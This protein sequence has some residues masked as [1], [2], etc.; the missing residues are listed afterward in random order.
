MKIKFYTL[1][2]LLLLSI[3]HLYADDAIIDGIAYTFNEINQ[4]AEVTSGGHYSGEVVIPGSVTYNGK[5]YSVT[6]IGK[7][8]FWGCSGLTSITIPNSV[9]S[10]GES[11]FTNCSGLTSVTISNNVTSLEYRTFASCSS[12]TSITLPN[13]VKIIGEAAFRGS[14]LTSITPATLNNVTSIGKEAFR[15]C[16]NL[17]S[18]T[19][20]NNVKYIGS[21][22]FQECAS[23]IS[24]I[25]SNSVTSI[26]YGAF[27]DCS[28]LTSVTLGNS[29]NNIGSRA[30]LNCS[31]LTSLT[32][33]NSV[34]SIGSCA[35][36]QCSGLTSVTIGNSVTSIG[37]YAFDLCSG[38]TNL[39]IGNSVTSIGD[40]AFFD[41]D[42]LTSV[43]IPVRVKNLGGG[44]FA[45]CSG[46]K[47]IICLVNKPPEL[48]SNVC[49]VDDKSIPTLFVPNI[50]EYNI[51]PWTAYFKDINS[52]IVVEEADV[53]VA[54]RWPKFNSAYTYELNLMDDFD[55][56]ATCTLTIDADGNL[57]SIKQTTN[58]FSEP[59]QTQTT[60]V[61][62]TISGLK[63]G[64][65]YAYNIIARAENGNILYR[66][67][68]DYFLTKGDAP[69]SIDELNTSNEFEGATKSFRNGL[70][71]IQRGDEV[72]NAQGARV[73]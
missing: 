24:V 34:T 45:S 21:C 32:I 71:F 28:A 46:L 22:A 15:W 58:W 6:S 49:P 56:K 65:Y 57:M 11:A 9:T 25:I 55:D 59:K 19:I 1:A 18:V 68:T 29:V 50:S 26:G 67:E 2:L 13:S 43:T 52:I 62:Y 8:S 20:G 7:E 14:G 38:L 42:N 51:W 39:V 53:S 40:Y 48:V 33:P 35:F 41:C 54:I 12:L 69:S 16:K 3:G 66:S 72:F 36:E 37:D 30:F 5:N 10:I 61:A 70:L 64:T 44:V 60:C 27:W 47:S 73:E 23:L 17:T 31:A 4:T 63:S